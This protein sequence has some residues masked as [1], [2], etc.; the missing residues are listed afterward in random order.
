MEDGSITESSH[1]RANVEDSSEAMVDLANNLAVWT[2]K[3]EELIWANND[4]S[5][6]NTIQ[7]GINAPANHTH[8]G[9]QNE[10]LINSR[11]SLR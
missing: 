4:D 5:L 2:I 6:H 3:M 8:E 10:T 7:D 1:K 11:L 9:F